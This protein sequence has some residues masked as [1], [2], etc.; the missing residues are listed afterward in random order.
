MSGQGNTVITPF[1]FADGYHL[2]AGSPAID[3]GIDPV[4]NDV[5]AL[6]IDGDARTLGART[7]IGADEF[8][9]PPPPPNPD[10]G[11]GP[12]APGPGDQ[13][14]T[15]PNGPGGALD[16][17]APRFLGALAI[18]P[19]RFRRNAALS[20]RLDEAATVRFTI[21]R[22]RPGRRVN[23]RCVRPT[24]RNRRRPRCARHVDV[25]T[26]SATAAA[27]PT[28]L[29]FTRRLPPGRYRLVA[30]ARDAAGNT[31]TAV[32]TTFRIVRRR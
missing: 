14:G 8:V 25:G 20:F 32:R 5:A 31:S 1:T 16:R 9:P 13:P 27:G 23:R 15:G 3:A 24:P 11:G 17:A 22:R 30:V 2:P 26:F 6:D 7:D 29:R 21:Q 4:P 28:Q 18:T 19:R 10:G 12:S